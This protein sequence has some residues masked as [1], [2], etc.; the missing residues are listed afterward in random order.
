MAECGA[1]PTRITNCRRRAPVSLRGLLKELLNRRPVNAPP[2]QPSRE[3]FDGI[4]VIAPR[5]KRITARH[6]IFDVP[7]RNW[8][9]RIDRDMRID[10]PVMQLACR[11]RR[12]PFCLK[13]KRKAS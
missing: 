10:L 13:G 5:A 9:D 6:Q 8:F 3:L 12:L 7:F 11:H 2:A 1:I 4:N